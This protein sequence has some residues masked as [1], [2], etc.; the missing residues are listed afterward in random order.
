MK[1]IRLAAIAGAVLALGL[2]TADAQAQMRKVKVATEGAYAPWNFVNSQGKLEGFELDLGAELCKR[3]KLDCEFV[4]Q[5]WDGIMPSLLAKKYDA[6]MA[7]MNI[8]PKRMETINFTTAYAAGPHGLLILKSS[9]LAKLPA[10]EYNLTKDL[11]EAE[12]AIAAITP[13]LKG[14]IIGVQ[15]STTNLAWAEKYFKGVAEIREYKTTEQHD[16]DLAAGRIDAAVVA[17]SAAQ[18]TMETATGKDMTMAPPSFSGGMLGLGVAVGIRKED[19]DLKNAFDAAVKAAI[20]DG[21][22]KTLSIKW[23]KVDMTPKS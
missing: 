12:K 23:F 1:I 10:G 18:A 20:A 6:I 9:A 22:I 17:H 13:Q 11:A 14:K 19:N 2:A 3:A 8:T 16:L 7:G 21:T 4:A 15:G 5:D